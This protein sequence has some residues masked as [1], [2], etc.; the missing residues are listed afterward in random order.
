M[1]DEPQSDVIEQAIGIVAAQ[2]GCDRA[3]ALQAMR[4]IGAATDESLES[5]ARYVLDG[6]VKLG[7]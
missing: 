6:T 5:V 7:E 4:D 2:L 3:D 1:P